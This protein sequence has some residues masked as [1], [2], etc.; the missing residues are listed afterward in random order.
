MDDGSYLKVHLFFL[1]GTQNG[2]VS[3][4]RGCLHLIKGS[5]GR[6]VLQVNG[7]VRKPHISLLLQAGPWDGSARPVLNK[8]S[9]A[10][11]QKHPAEPER[12]TR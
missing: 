2:G 7:V 12:G 8:P 1:N 3:R 9:L 5:L 11:L 4:N 6:S 10:K